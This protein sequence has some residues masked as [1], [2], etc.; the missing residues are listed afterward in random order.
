[1]RRLILS[2]TITLTVSLSAFAQRGPGYWHMEWAVD[3]GDSIAMVYIL[4]IYKYARKA[5]MRRYQ[6]LVRAVKKVYPI[7]QTAKLE[8][9][10]MEEELSRLK[11]RKEQREYVKGVQERI[12][13]Q[14]TPVLKRMTRYEGRILLKLIDRET[15]FTAYEIVKELRGGFVAGFWQGMARLFGN[16]LK[17]GYDKDG[18]DRMVE[19]V[20]VMYERGLI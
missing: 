1:M 3:H 13:N 4:P 18:D 5:D 2:I 15:E 8:M 11:T 7:A 19:Y 14:Y 9:G 6:K 17:L 20:V 10:D 16:N 12:I